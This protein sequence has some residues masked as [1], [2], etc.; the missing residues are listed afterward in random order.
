MAFG[1]ARYL[2][3]CGLIVRGFAAR[4]EAPPEMPPPAP[5]HADPPT[6][7]DLKDFG[8][9]VFTSGF[10]PDYSWVKAPGAFDEMGFPV[11]V[12]GSSTVVPG[13]HFMGV[14]FQRKR[15]SATLLGWRRMPRSSPSECS[16]EPGASAPR[17]EPVVLVSPGSG[18]P[19]PGHWNRVAKPFRDIS[20]AGSARSPR[21]ASSMA[22][23]LA[24]DFAAVGHCRDARCLVERS[25]EIQ[26]RPGNRCASACNLM[27]T[28]G[29]KPVNS[30]PCS[31]SAT[32]MKIAQSNAAAESSNATR[33]IRPRG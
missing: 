5:F 21:P 26:S 22:A 11:Q 16:R 3:L 8:A 19:D 20:T 31:T 28:R 10:R 29:G 12:D 32:W 24:R 13:L 15:K 4:G 6:S 7:L 18:P 2:D 23:A 17:R 14:H 25:A 30:R 1:D 27:R 9:I 33:R